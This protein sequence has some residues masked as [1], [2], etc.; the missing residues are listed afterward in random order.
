MAPLFPMSD[1]N[2]LFERFTARRYR[3]L[4]YLPASLRLMQCLPKCRVR[5]LDHPRCQHEYGRRNRDAERLGGFH[6]D[7]ELKLGGLLDGQIAGLCAFEYLDHKGR[8][9]SKH[10]GEVRPIG[11]E[12]TT[13]DKT[14]RFIDCRYSVVRRKRDNARTLLKRHWIE[15]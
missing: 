14:R 12:S 11:N 7:H 15:D 8:G 2:P 10:V 1:G 9:A 5:L 13:F 6:V 4:D 3:L